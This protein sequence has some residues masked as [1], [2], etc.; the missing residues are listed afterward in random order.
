MLAWIYS[1][2]ILK[3]YQLAARWIPLSINP[4]VGLT[5]IIYAGLEPDDPKAEYV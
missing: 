1:P 3:P 4:F 2:P 5:R